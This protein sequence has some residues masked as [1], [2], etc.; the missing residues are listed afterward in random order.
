VV[1][2]GRTFS[3]IRVTYGRIFLLRDARGGG[4]KLKRRRLLVNGEWE[5]GW[6]SY[7]YV[8]DDDV[9]DLLSNFRIGAYCGRF[10]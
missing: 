6:K 1:V 8:Y 3:F 5:E 2:L 9:Y 7:E 10:C 4:R